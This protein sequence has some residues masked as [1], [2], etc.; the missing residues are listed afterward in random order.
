[1]KHNIRKEIINRLIRDYNFKEENN[2]LRYGVCPQCGKKELFTSLERPYIV[3]CG[4]ENKCGIDLPTKELYPDV[5]SSWSDRYISTKDEPYAAAAAY[6]QEVRNIAVEPLKGAFTQERF[7]DKESGEQAATVRFTLADGV[8]W[9]RIIDRPER[10]ARKAN[11]S[12]SYKGLWWAYPG[13]DLSKAKEIWI[14]EGVFDAISLNQNGIAAVSAMSAVNYPDKALEELAKLCGDNPRP[15]IVWALDNGRAGERYAKKHAERSAESGWRTA[16][17]LP[18]ENNNKRDWNDLHI[19]GKLRS[20]DV[21]RY[22]YYGDLLLAKSP[23]D[24]ALIIFSFCERKEFHFTFDNRVFWFKL[25][26]ER[27]MKAVERAKNERN[28][29][30][31]EAR[32]IALKESGTVKEIANCNPAPLYYI[33][34]NDTDEAWYYFRVT[35]PDGATVK[36]TFTSGQLTSASEFKKR[37]LHVA[38]GGI[39]TGTTAHLDALIKND[40][41]AIKNVIGQD[42]IG[43]NKEIGAWLF[44]DVA[45]CNGKTYEINEEDYFEID[46]INAKPLNKKP[47][48]QINYKKP[49]EFTTSWAEDLWLAFGEKGIITLAFWLGSLFSEQ[50][51]Q[52]N[53]SYP[54]LEITG[55]PGTGKTTLIDFCWRLCGRDNYEGVD[56]TKGSESGWKRTFGQV[57]GLPVVLIEADRGDNAQKRGAFDFDNLKSLY[58]GGGIGVRGVKTNDNTTYD[59]VFK[60]AIVIAQ[61]ATVNAS[62]AIIERLVR[63]YTDKKRHS[64]D[65]R[66]AAKRLELYPVEQ[67]SGFIHRAVSQERAIMETFMALSDPETTRLHEC[68]NIRHQRIAKNHAQLIALVRALKCVIDIPDEWLNATCQELERMAA[69]QAKAVTGDLPEVIAFWEAFDYLDGITAYGVNHFGKGFQDGL[70]VSIPQLE[71]V[72]AVHHVKIQTNP[73]MIKLLKA[74]RSRPLIGYKSVRSEVVKQANTGRGVAQAKENEVLKCWIFGY[75][76]RS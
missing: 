13:A 59:P 29:D 61:N 20:H 49:D 47:T 11:F 23:R 73:E 2:Y 39:Y 22:R 21:K 10:F 4:R 34:N 27:Y 18:G 9:E 67:V 45:V 8:W 5:F 54:F 41:P 30:E 7:Q 68:E 52:K 36:N 62:S 43:Y 55:E 51:R 48:L 50:I 75:K 42:F 37:L 12:G 35:F 58:N 72:A 26:I 17:A 46:G 60:G 19:A 76:E 70:A 14:C 66:L 24:K 63:V 6:L 25:D 65:S 56:P 1:M 69:E 31:D 57:A 28:V 44:N 38:K 64:P 16:A 74:G 3:H 15:V 40:L 71:Q 53:T 33:R 32:K